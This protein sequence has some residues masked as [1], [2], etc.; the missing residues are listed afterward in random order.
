LVSPASGDMS[1]IWFSLKLTRN[2]ICR[3][4]EHQVQ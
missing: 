1:L 4:N 2:R 3:Y